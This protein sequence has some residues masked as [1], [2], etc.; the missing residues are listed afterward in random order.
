[1]DLTQKHIYTKRAFY[2][3]IY[4]FVLS[5]KILKRDVF[6]ILVRR[7]SHCVCHNNMPV[8]TQMLS[9]DQSLLSLWDRACCMQQ[10]AKL[11]KCYITFKLD[12]IIT[13]FRRERLHHSSGIFAIVTP[14]Q[15]LPQNAWNFGVLSRT[16]NYKSTLTESSFGVLLSIINRLRWLALMLTAHTNQ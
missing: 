1:M 2:Q 12:V 8:N 4:S 5:F 10:V 13:F 7:W 15:K 9:S 16:L 14:L 6:P 3:Q 11:R